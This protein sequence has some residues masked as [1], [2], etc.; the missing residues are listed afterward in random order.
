[1]NTLVLGIGTG[2]CGTKSLVRLL[3]YQNNTRV[4]HER[5]GP[6]VRWNTPPNLWPLRLWERSKDIDSKIVSDVA[7]YWTW[8]IDTFL[9]WADKEGRKVRII[10]LKRDKKETIQSYLQWK[11]NSDHWTTHGYTK[12]GP[13]E[14]DKCYPSFNVDSK[15]VAIGLFWEKTY[16]KIEGYPDERVRCFPTEYLNTDPGVNEIL[17]HVGY[18]DKNVKVGLKIKAPNINEA[19]NSTQW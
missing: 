7:F 13:D 14:W 17:N 11:P 2:R 19:R 1:M 3:E 4:T 9:K 16:D 10:G 18:E 8:H 12:E 5:Y 15:A 6:K